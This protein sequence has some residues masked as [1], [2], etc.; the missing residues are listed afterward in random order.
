M[1]EDSNPKLHSIVA[2]VST[3]L[4]VFIFQILSCETL[5]HTYVKDSL[6]KHKLNKPLPAH[7]RHMMSP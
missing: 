3:Y 1:K 2:E 5:L 7:Y 6:R 4:G